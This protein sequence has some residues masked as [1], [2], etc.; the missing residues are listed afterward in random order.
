V[1]SM[2]RVTDWSQ[3]YSE[4]HFVGGTHATD[5]VYGESTKLSDYVV[6]PSINRYR[7]TRIPL[8]GGDGPRDAG[9]RAMLERNKRAGDAETVRARAGSGTNYGGELWRPNQLHLVRD[10]LL[11]LNDARMLISDVDYD[12][13]VRMPDGFAAD[14]T[15]KRPEAFDYRASYP[16]EAREG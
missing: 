7:P 12:F 9:V 10:P 3:R 16:A 6:D 5:D 4:Y 14:I 13:G 15:L 2:E 8:R 11:R 1:I